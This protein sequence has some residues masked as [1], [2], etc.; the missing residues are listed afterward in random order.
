MRLINS[1]IFSIIVLV[2]IV[3]AQNWHSIGPGGAPLSICFSSKYIL[4][5]TEYVGIAKSTDNGVSWKFVQGI[6]TGNTFNNAVMCIKHDP[7]NSQ[8][9]Y[10]GTGPD[11]TSSGNGFFK[12]TD[13]GETWQ[14]KNTGL[15]QQPA[16]SEI[17]INPFH[18]NEIYINCRSNSGYSI[19]SSVD[20]GETWNLFFQDQYLISTLIF[21]AMD[22]T[23]QYAIGTNGTVYRWKDSSYSKFIPSSDPFTYE[24]HPWTFL[25][26]KTGSLFYV[27]ETNLYKWK[28]DSD[29][30][31]LL[32]NLQEKGV[33]IT[34]ITDAT[35]NQQSE[36]IFICTDKGVFTSIDDGSN[37]NLND[38]LGDMKISIDSAEV[39]L[40]GFNGLYHST[41]NGSYWSKISDGPKISSIYQTSIIPTSTGGVIYAIG[42]DNSFLM[43]NTLFKTTDG[44]DSWIKVKLPNQ[45]TPSVIKA[46]PYNPNIIYLGGI[47]YSGGVSI[48]SLYKSFDGGINWTNVLPNTE[49]NYIEIFPDD[50]SHILVGSFGKI[51]ESFNS[52]NSWG[53]YLTDLNSS[54]Y[55]VNIV[56]VSSKNPAVV[57][58]A[59]SGNTDVVS[60]FFIST[61]GGNFWER[62]MNGISDDIDHITLSAIAVDPKNPNNIFIGNNAGIYKTTNMGNNWTSC[63]NMGPV[64]DIKIAQDNPN[65]IF[66]SSQGPAYGTGGLF[67]SKDGGNSWERVSFP[68][69]S[70]ESRTS[71]DILPVGDKYKIFTGTTSYGCFEGEYTREIMLPLKPQLISPVDTTNVPLLANLIW[72]PSDLAE[73]Y[74]LQIAKDSSF[75]TDIFDTTLTDTTLQLHNLLS[76]NTQYFW[77]V[78]AV[79]I[80]GDTSY[81][82][83]A[84]F[85]TGILESVKNKEI[86]APKTFALYQNYPNPFN[87]STTIIFD[88]RETS[89]VKLTVYDILG[90]KLKD[91]NLGEMNTGTYKKV[92][93]MS[94]F[95][96]GIY[97][98]RFIAEGI[99]GKRFTSLKKMILEK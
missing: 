77:H 74:Y 65:M 39:M 16:V 66:A 69:F 84:H 73:Q 64:S 4:A 20:S 40:V 99:D 80:N 87:P 33:K 97:F 59:I 3:F 89:A 12:S 22:S 61:T 49:V 27:T 88:L 25:N 29:W 26:S 48:S 75:S 78:N 14:V 28:N 68:G 15:P 44:G 91:L 19:Y 62:R 34:A 52:G 2:Q 1:F 95:S 96:S 13:G 70:N 90:E 24:S 5:G 30:V 7:N 45:M 85:T 93:D 60:G 35:I 79:N 23:L 71:I 51:L 83:T 94:H 38:S 18:T 72:H 55:E 42:N 46:N 43:T 53:S 17:S 98:Y 63:Y 9:I 67:L 76:A 10:A 21:N 92:I 8:I 6:P 41:N 57:C 50:T 54:Y 37:W 56:K 36:T 47:I 81:S 82:Q 86:A 31:S 32:S 11:E 58:A